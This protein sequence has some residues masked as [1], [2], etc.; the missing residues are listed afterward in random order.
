MFAGGGGGAAGANDSSKYGGGVSGGSPVSGYAASA[1]AA[2]TTGSFGI[3]GSHTGSYNYKYR[4]R[5]GG[6]GWYGGGCVASSSDSNADTVRGSNGGGSGYVYT[7]STAGNYPSGCLLNS[8]YYLTNAST[9]DGQSSFISP[10]GS[11]ETGHT[12][13]GYV[14]ITVIK[15]GG[16]PSVNIGG[17]WK[18]GDSLYVNIGGSWKKLT[19]FIVI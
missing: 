14:R 19:V 17:S 7:S 6:G 5:V 18:E 8:S 12:G 10:S 9:T 3:G 2:G 11:A 15:A 16:A 13:D 4:P 1:T